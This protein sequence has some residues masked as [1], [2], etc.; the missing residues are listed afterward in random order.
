MRFHRFQFSRDGSQAWY[1]D[2]LARF[3]F[4][5]HPTDPDC[6]VA[7]KTDCRVFGETMLGRGQL[8]VDVVNDTLSCV[9]RNQWTKLD[10]TT[11]QATHSMKLPTNLFVSAGSVVSIAGTLYGCADDGGLGDKARISI[12]AIRSATDIHVVP[13]EHKADGGMG[14]VP[15]VGVQIRDRQTIRVSMWYECKTARSVRGRVDRFLEFDVDAKTGL[16]VGN[17][18]PIKP[19]VIH[20][21][22]AVPLAIGPIIIDGQSV[23]AF[24]RVDELVF[25]V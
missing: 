25:A 16:P 7:T 3:R 22:F 12:V 15:R 6:V 9:E 20:P 2:A 14:T 10:P 21:G 17:G 13:V 8:I 24:Q 11:L 18:L 5:R 4:A 19:K 1:W 23:L